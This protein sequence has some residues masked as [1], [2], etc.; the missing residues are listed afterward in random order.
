MKNY[1]LQKAVG[2]KKKQ[3]KKEKNNTQQTKHLK[4]LPTI[5]VV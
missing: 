1:N 2:I 5:I 3:M 4:K